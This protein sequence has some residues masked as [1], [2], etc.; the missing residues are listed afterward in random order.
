MG[1]PSVLA[2]ELVVIPAASADAISALGSRADGGF[3]QIE[4]GHGA[5]EAWSNDEVGAFF[6][7]DLL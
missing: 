1:R 4:L 5:H 2:R 6:R 7:R 3:E